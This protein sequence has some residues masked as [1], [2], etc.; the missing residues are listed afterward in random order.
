MKYVDLI[1]PG[2]ASNDLA[3]NILVENLN[4]YLKRRKGKR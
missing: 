2:G 4:Q 3:I 1:I